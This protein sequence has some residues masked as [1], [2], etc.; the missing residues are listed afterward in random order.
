[1]QGTHHLCGSVGA[2][3]LAPPANPPHRVLD[4]F[5]RR[6]YDYLSGWQEESSLALV[7]EQLRQV[8]S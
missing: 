5:R 2:L 3:G 6:D 1:V 7:Y 4:A 8:P